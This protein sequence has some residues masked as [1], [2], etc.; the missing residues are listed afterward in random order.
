MSD[1][2]SELL[3]NNTKEEIL[4]YI[5]SALEKSDE[6]PFW[7]EKI[8]PFVD[9]ILSVLLALKEQNLL[10]TPEGEIKQNLDSALF[11]EWADLICLRTLAFTLELSNAQNK[12]LRT[13]YKDVTYK[14]VDLEILGKYLSSYKVNLTDEDHLDFPVGNYNLHIGMVTII[15][16][17]F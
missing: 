14:K 16:S 7:K 6:A 9:A 15:K 17:F 1:K 10:F 8:V 3:Q 12:L 2:L 4:E 11:Y 13:S 5:E